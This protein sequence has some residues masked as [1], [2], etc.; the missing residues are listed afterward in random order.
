M[1]V[2]G[3]TI[4]IWVVAFGRQNHGAHRAALSPEKVPLNTI[5]IPSSPFITANKLVNAETYDYST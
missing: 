4:L 3:S 2:P 1:K 5:W